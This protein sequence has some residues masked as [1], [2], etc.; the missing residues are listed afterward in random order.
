MIC[1][2]IWKNRNEVRHGGQD[3]RGSAIVRSA[4]MMLEEFQA[5]NVKQ[6]KEG[7]HM[8]EVVKWKPPQLGRYKVNTDGA[9]FTK[10]KS[11]GIGVV[12]RDS[13]GEVIAALCKRVAGLMG[14]LETE[15]IAMEV[16]VQFAADIGL[17]DVVFEVDSLSVCKMIQG[18]TEV[19]S[20][21]QNVVDGINAQLQAFRI[22]E[23]SYVKRQG[24]I[25]VDLIS[26]A[27][28]TR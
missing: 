20:S 5:V 26:S 18:F 12:V 23:V 2:G 14:A 17:R 13:K 7:T 1:W 16:A 19:Q 21:I 27:C 3:K 4:L 10:S 15:A 6:I 24:N 8:P 11:V 28:C 9:V 22:V 25:P